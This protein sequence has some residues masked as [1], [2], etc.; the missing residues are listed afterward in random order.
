MINYLHC[1]LNQEDKLPGKILEKLI[2]S[3]IHLHSISNPHQ[4]SIYGLY[5]FL[6][7]LLKN[8]KIMHKN[9]KFE[10]F[11]VMFVQLWWKM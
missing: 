1:N 10:K 2:L 5:L 4:K 3:I 7:N 8:W 6:D 11:L 9:N